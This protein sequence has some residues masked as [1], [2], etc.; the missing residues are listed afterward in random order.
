MF[1]DNNKPTLKWF[2]KLIALKF[3]ELKTQEMPILNFD[4]T[5]CGVYVLIHG[6]TKHF[7]IGSTHDLYKR[8]YKHLWHIKRKD[9]RNTNIN[10][11]FTDFPTTNIHFLYWITK[12]KEEA[13]DIE[14]RFLD[15]AHRHNKCLNISSDAR[16]S[17]KDIIMTETSKKL[18]I[19]NLKKA[20]ENPELR[21]K[22]S[23]SLKKYFSDPN[24]INKLRDSVNK[25]VQKPEF[26]LKQS[27]NSIKQWSDPEARRKKSEEKKALWR[28][29]EKR[30]KQLLLYTSRRKKVSINN[31]IYNNLS[32][33]SDKINLSVPS[34]L[35]RIH[36]DNFPEW[37]YVEKEINN[38]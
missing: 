17:F 18:M 30:K 31:V 23:L 13:L 26:K 8:K 27:I 3:A 15:A 32:E 7:Y 38:V 29:P 33:A 34:I 35:Y 19:K 4:N 10:K 9:H 2:Q 21:L 24:N 20:W 5:S 28:D 6:N 22:Q 11:I 12:T 25:V 16:K 14:Q 1:S 36:L 37:F